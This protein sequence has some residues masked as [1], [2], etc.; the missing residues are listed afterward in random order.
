M[1]WNYRIVKKCGIYQIYEVY[2]DKKGRPEAVSA[3]PIALMGETREQLSG[4][5]LLQSMAFHKDVLDYNKLLK[6][7]RSNAREE[8]KTK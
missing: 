6:E 2:Y 7:I 8:R 1:S 4:D 5:M 3:D